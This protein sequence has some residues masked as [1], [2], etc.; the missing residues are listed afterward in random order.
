[1][2][3]ILIKMILMKSQKIIELLR[4]ALGFIFLWSFL[5]ALFG[6][7]EAIT[8][9]K[10]WLAGNSPTYGFLKFASKGA[11]SGLFSAIAG[12]ILVDWFYMMGL[13]G[14][15]LA[16]IL[17]IGLNIAVYSGALMMFLIYLSRFP[18]EH[19]PIIDEHIIYI[20]LLF[21]LKDN[22]GKFWS[23]RENWVKLDLV[24]KNKFLR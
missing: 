8:P 15:G 10:S 6:L 18:P 17:G 20:L 5:N 21:F 3:K 9:D 2:P 12:N 7:S 11:F 22:S 4:L 24:K 16:L 19:N 1:M 23:I 14:V 13:L